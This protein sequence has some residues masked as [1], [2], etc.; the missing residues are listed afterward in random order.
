MW[1]KQ[2]RL[3]AVET[4]PITCV[5]GKHCHTVQLLEFASSTVHLYSYKVADVWQGAMYDYRQ[6]AWPGTYPSYYGPTMQWSVLTDWLSNSSYKMCVQWT[7]CLNWTV[8]FIFWYKCCQYFWVKQWIYVCH[9]LVVLMLRPVVIMCSDCEQYSTFDWH[10]RGLAC[11]Q[12]IVAC[13]V[14]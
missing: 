14:H 7:V 3:V 2:I 1:R 9:C 6:A 5:R 12:L 4:R 8:C 13:F 11:Q 10:M